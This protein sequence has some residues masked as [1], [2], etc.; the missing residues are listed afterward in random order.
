[1]PKEVSDDKK[2]YLHP[3]VQAGWDKGD[4]LLFRPENLIAT[5]V[6]A[7]SAPYRAGLI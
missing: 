3:R 6:P 4:I 5:A 1:M 7:P 2:K